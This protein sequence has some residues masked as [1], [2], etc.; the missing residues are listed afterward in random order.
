MMW[1]AM[2]GVERIV[3]K[4]WLSLPC[5]IESEDENNTETKIG[6]DD[7]A[8]QVDENPCKFWTVLFFSPQ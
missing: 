8:P 3:M 4:T 5:A 1:K 6:E 7:E 2:K